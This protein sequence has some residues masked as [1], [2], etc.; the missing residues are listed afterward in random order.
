MHAM[1]A[2]V[3][4]VIII[5]AVDSFYMLL[6]HHACGLFAICGFQIKRATKTNSEDIHSISD[7]RAIYRQ[8]RK[9]ATSHKKAIHFYELLENMN[10][11]S[12]LLQIGFIMIGISV[13]AVQ[14]MMNIDNKSE[15][16]RI[17]L[18]LG[19]QQF[20]LFF[21]CLPGQRLVD[22][23]LQLGEDLFTSEWYQTPVRIQ[24]LLI[25]MQ[26]RSG[27]PCTLS[28]GGMYNLNIENYGIIFKTCMSY[29][30]MLMSL[31]E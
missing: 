9:C 14:T 21:T 4:V 25:I 24:K 30:T 1:L 3:T 31:R 19:G 27:I 5:L 7:E 6:S 8:F 2:V 10:R 13:T 20:H 17:A 18:F 22:H 28:A 12:F 23:S 29:F 15:A 11:R 16:L 26:M